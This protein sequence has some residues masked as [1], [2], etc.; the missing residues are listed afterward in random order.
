M[1]KTLGSFGDSL[2]Q[3]VSGIFPDGGIGN[4]AGYA[5]KALNSSS[6]SGAL[7]YVMDAQSYVM[8]KIWG[9]T[10]FPGTVTIF[11]D[12][13]QFKPS[14]F[15]HLPI[16][17]GIEEISIPFCD[18][19]SVEKVKKGLLKISGF[20]INLQDSEFLVLAPFATDKIISLMKDH[21][22]IR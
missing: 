18:I 19:Q 2:T 22:A 11:T 15:I 7:N 21:V 13:F 16:Y 1:T 20:K 14:F 3:T 9:G 8:K 4:L 6:G 10:P 17:Q 12:K 5:I